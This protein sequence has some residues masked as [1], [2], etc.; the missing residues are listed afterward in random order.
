M[1]THV[2]VETSEDIQCED[3]KSDL[4]IVERHKN[5]S[6]DILCGQAEIPKNK[7][8]LLPLLLFK[9]EWEITEKKQTK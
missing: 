8:K 7:I 2:V 9:L 4:Q 1:Y 5:E 3:K 6:G